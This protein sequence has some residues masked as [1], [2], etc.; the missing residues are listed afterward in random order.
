M[1]S[2]P[3]SS[4]NFILFTQVHLGD[5]PSKETIKLKTIASFQQPRHRT[6]TYIM[7][8]KRRPAA[9]PADA[10]IARHG[11]GRNSEWHEWTRY[12]R[13]AD[14]ELFRYAD[15]RSRGQK[16]AL[17]HMRWERCPEEREYHRKLLD[18]KVQVRQ[19]GSD[20]FDTVDYE[21]PYSGRGGRWPLL[22]FSPMTCRKV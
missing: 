4:P 2:L 22:R 13:Q 19:D 3:L 10:F 16:P 21:K 7:P 6:S 5:Q 11:R 20:I 1:A 9:T 12:Y 18:R 17:Y 14:P 15:R 8:P